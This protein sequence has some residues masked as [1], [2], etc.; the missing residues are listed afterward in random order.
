MKYC[1]IIKSLLFLA[2]DGFWKF[3]SELW[4]GEN[5][6][7]TTSNVNG[8]ASMAAKK[9]MDEKVNKWTS[10][11]SSRILR[12]GSIG[13]HEGRFQLESKDVFKD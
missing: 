11:L 9:Y 3:C 7:V 8:L 4:Q 2:Q 1:E 12:S 6:A 10:D 13:A 5:V